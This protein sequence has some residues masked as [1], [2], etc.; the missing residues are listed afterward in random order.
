M[1]EQPLL[2]RIA[3]VTGG[4]SGIGAACVSA[5]A[6]A[7]AD[8]C[9]I[10]YED[11]EAGE[12]SAGAARALGRRAAAARADVGSETDVDAAFDAI[13]AAVGVPDILVNSAGINMSGVKVADMDVGQWERM[14]RTDLTGSFLTSRRFLRDLLPSGRPGAIVNITSIHAFAMRPGGAD[15]D[16]AKGGQRN[17][18]RTLALEVA[19]AGVTVNAIAPGMILTP[20]NARAMTDARYREGLEASIPV[21]RAGRPE[22]VAGVAVFL[23]SPAASYITGATIVIDGG[24]SLVLGQGA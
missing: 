19:Q 17:L 8:V 10:Y 22:D 23:A 12:A 9:V 13:G 14:L 11:A 1:P 24:L 4:E 15:Y 18:T 2:D 16:A 5:L 20:M 6:A 7:G 3:V 21:R